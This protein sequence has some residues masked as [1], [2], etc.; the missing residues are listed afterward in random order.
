MAFGSSQAAEKKI[1][2]VNELITTQTPVAAAGPQVQLAEAPAQGLYLIQFRDR[3]DTAWGDQLKN[4]KVELIRYIPDDAFIC[5]LSGAQVGVLR[6]LPFVQYVGPYMAAYKIHPKVAQ[7][8]KA[9]GSVKIRALLPATLSAQDLGL[10]K[11]SFLRMEKDISSRFGRILQGTVTSDQLNRLANSSAVLWIEHAPKPRLFDEIATKIVAGDDDSTGTG[12]VAHQLGFDGTGVTVAVADSGLHTGTAEAMHPDLAGR[13]DAFFYYGELTDAADE[14]SHGTHVTG[15]VAGNA[16]LGEADEDGYRY[17]L[18]VAPNAHIV[19]QRIFDGAGNFEAP[20]TYEILTHDAVRAGAKIGS[21]SWGDD[22]QGAYDLS[23]AEYDGYVRDADAG[24]PGDQPYILEFSA[25]N[26]GPG[27][28]TIDSPAVAKNV[29]ATGAAQNDRFNFGIYAEGHDSMADFSSRG[30]CQDGRIKPDV[31]APGTWIASLRSAFANDENAWAGIS[32]NYMYQGGTSQAGPHVSGAA[33][34]FVQYYKET[35]T[36]A[37]PSP[38]LVKAALINSAVDMDDQSG[39]GPVPN[40]DEGWGRVDLTQIIGSRKHYDFLDQS[41]LLSQGQVFEKRV[42]VASGNE[43]LKI[44]LTYTDVPGFPGAIPALVNDLDLEVVAPNGSIYRGNQFDH[45]ES[46]PDASANDPINNVEGV[47][48]KAPAPGEY[49]IRVKARNVVADSRKDTPSVDQDFAL[50]VSGDLPLPGNGVVFFDRNAYRAADLIN[51]RLIDFDLGGQSTAVVQLQSTTESPGE[52]I[53]LH[54]LGSVGVFTGAV[55]TATGPA[56]AD[57]RLQIAH[58]DIIEVRYFDASAGVTRTN[59][60]IADLVPPILSG[61]TTLARFGKTAV[62]WIANEPVTAVVRYGTNASN[63]NLAVTNRSLTTTPQVVLGGLIEGFNYYYL[64]VSADEA[65]NLTTNNN[66]GSLFNFVAQ[67]TAP[68]LLVNAYEVFVSTDPLDPDPGPTSDI[69]LTTYTSALQQVGAAFDVWDVTAN[70][71]PG[72]NDLLPYRVVIWRVNDDFNASGTPRATLSL[73]NQSAITNYLS[74]GGAVFI[75]SM[76][77]LSRLGDVP[78]RR[79]VLQ[80]AGFSSNPDPFSPCPTCDE[81]HGVAGIEGADGDIVSRDM[82]MT[83]DYSAYPF[84]DFTDIGL[85]LIIGPDLGD[86][87]VPTTNAVPIFR[88]PG[89]R[90]AGIRYPRTGQDNGRLIFLPFP[91]DAIP[92]TGSAPNN[93]ASVLRRALQFLAPGLNGV[94]TISLDSSKYT[95]PSLVTVEVGDSD[96]AGHGFTSVTFRSTTDTNGLTVTLQETTLRGLFRG[97]ITL[98]SST[99]AAK[100]GFLRSKEGDSIWVDYLDASGGGNVRAIATIDTIPPVVS[101]VAVLPQ[102]Q[103]ATIAWET[104]E[105]TDATVQFGESAFLG[106]TAF[107]PDIGDIHEAVLTGLVPNKVYYYRLISRDI[108]GNT[109]IYPTNETLLSFRTL[110]AVSPPWFDNLETSTSVTN[111]TVVD[112]EVT[113]LSW[114]LGAPANSVASSAHSPVNAWGTNLRGDY[115]DTGDTTLLSPVFQL[116]GGTQAHLRFW[117]NYNFLPTSEFDLYEYGDLYITTNNGGS[118]ILLAEFGTSSTGWEFRDI[119]ITA[120]IGQT[121][122]FSWVYAMSSFDFGE[123]PGWLIDDISVVVSGLAVSNNLAQASFTIFGPGTNYIG[124]GLNFSPT[125][126]PP[127]QYRI[128]F[129]PVAYYQTPLNQT[130][131]YSDTNAVLFIGNY[132]IVDANNNGMADAWEQAFFGGV[133]PGHLAA[134]DSDGDGMSDF[135]EFMAGT[136]PT[137]RLSMLSLSATPA[138]GGFVQ[139]NWPSGSGR[140]YRVLGSSNLINWTPSSSWITATGQNSQVIIPPTNGTVRFFKLEVRP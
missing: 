101:S 87:F 64:V 47:H 28:Q 122:R 95:I 86:T 62:N 128:Q 39:T 46:V 43:P 4:L 17:G 54:A 92:E 90:V 135:A 113:T 10:T 60:A 107:D 42:I 30:P 85:N 68:I 109:T 37:V 98:V 105:F 84:I 56:V 57:G 51:I 121:V 14:H 24:T 104:D 114:T 36:N 70:G 117:Q 2:L 59:S 127:G 40:N 88:E 32:D 12:A 49:I 13:V 73:A 137:N 131:T 125:N 44:T 38:A 118:Q 20:P 41:V 23:A 126:P 19:V 140:D 96:L 79:N 9:T 89:G 132:T 18:G 31:V 99:N 80:V 66:N 75:S 3:Y 111:W 82:L 78:F 8:A 1:R 33:A 15:I 133:V 6:R 35:V 110:K 124:H 108:A 106:R 55:A 22:V 119:D 26:A 91:L 103:E 63:L 11:R 34:V 69:P 77:L 71:M 21:N 115:S 120:Y 94:G 25:G 65:G 100:P 138:S 112:G 50:V 72:A 116:E 83:L 61:V 97:Y 67:P 5:R 134:T 81:D 76:E 130:N 7:Q 29:I 136:N 102:Y 16:T 93:R 74:H 129:D 52:S 53:L 139:F 45:G 123:H 48:L 27:E 58:G